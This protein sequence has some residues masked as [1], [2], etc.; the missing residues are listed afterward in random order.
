VVATPES[1]KPR[2]LKVHCDP[3][4][5]ERNYLETDLDSFNDARPDP[6]TPVLPTTHKLPPGL[7]NAHLLKLKFL[8]MDPRSPSEGIPRTPI[9]VS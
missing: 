4:G 7:S 9:Q 1:N 5:A 6:S 8:G 3:N 2:K